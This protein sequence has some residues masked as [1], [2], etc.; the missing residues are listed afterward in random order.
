MMTSSGRG[1]QRGASLLALV[2]HVV[3]DLERGE[4]RGGVRSGARVR[5]SVA[6]SE[7]ARSFVS[8]QL[9]VVE[10][11]VGSIPSR[12]LISR[13]KPQAKAPASACHVVVALDGLVRDARSRLVRCERLQPI[14]LQIGCKHLAG[15]VR[16]IPLDRRS[17]RSR[18]RWEEQLDGY[19]SDL[20]E[21]MESH[22][23][24]ELGILVTGGESNRVLLAC[25]GIVNSANEAYRGAC[26]VGAVEW[27][28]R[29]D[30]GVFLGGGGVC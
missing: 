7:D 12:E 21:L 6:S 16:Q 14:R 8:V 1:G 19:A 3:R 23:R 11:L 24:A 9:I 13:S 26:E 30:R 27:I 15:A 2:G 22:V 4:P 29:L 18:G 25:G 5:A 20:E 10:L 17:S 28:E